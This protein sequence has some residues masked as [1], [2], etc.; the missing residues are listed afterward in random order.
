[1]KRT[2]GLITMLI[3]A[4]TLSFADIA[5]PEKP[6]DPAKNTSLDTNLTIKLVKDAKEARLIIPRSQLRQLRAEL[7][8]IDPGSGETAAFGITRL[9]TILGGAFLSLAFVFAG[10]AF[11]RTGRMGGKSGPA[12]AA[13]LVAV[14]GLAFVSVAFG[15]VGPPAEARSITGKMFSR[16]VH[17]YGFGWG[18]IKLEVGDDNTTPTLI[19]PN[20]PEAK[21]EGEE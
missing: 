4:S 5:R 11:F 13:A 6:K 1:M 19:V 8:S 16:S 2:L 7:D 10:I 9:Q 12:A 15:N 18:K 20:P 3:L 21:P 14:A 17:L